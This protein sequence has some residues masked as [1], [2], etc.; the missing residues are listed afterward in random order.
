MS[1]ETDRG[2]K[3]TEK[4]KEGKRAGVRERERE[5]ER[6][7]DGGDEGSKESPLCRRLEAPLSD[8]LGAM[9][10]TPSLPPAMGL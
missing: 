4:P 1:E 9:G 6:E 2:T 3:V 10:E 8:V 5:R 7:R